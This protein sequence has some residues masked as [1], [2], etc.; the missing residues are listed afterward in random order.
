[1]LRKV[2]R[3]CLA[4]LLLGGATAAEAQ[5]SK[6]ETTIGADIVSRYIWRGQDLGSVSM[7]PTL[8]VAYKGLSLDAWGSVG[9]T[10]P[11]DTKEFDL[12]LSYTLGGFNIGLTDYWLSE[13]GDPK[14]R[15]FMYEAHRTNH[16][17][18]ANIGYD[19]GPLAFQW[20]T[21]L[22]GNDGLNR[23]GKRAYSSYFELEAPFKFASA[24]WTAT[25]GAVPYATDFYE[26]A[27]GFAVTNIALK[28]AKEIKVT[29]KFA[30]PLF[31]QVVAN[32]SS[33][34]AFFVVGFTLQP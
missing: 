20:Y 13:G 7:Q 11:D 4:A 16:V 23:S 33:Q 25:I 21:N 5:D 19:F 12:T 22:A 24:D 32:P 34:K 27:S 1:M 9:L 28:A 29:D 2:R 17:F 8:G 15:Y 26:K 3:L 10:D 18:E 14:G 31:A 30:I 6:I